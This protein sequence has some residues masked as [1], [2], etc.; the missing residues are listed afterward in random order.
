MTMQIT[1]DVLSFF[2]GSGFT[3]LMFLLYHYKQSYE[4]IKK[5]KSQKI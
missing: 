2:L 1:I 3:I 4:K 5:E